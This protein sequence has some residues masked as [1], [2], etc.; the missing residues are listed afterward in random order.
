[1]SVY[2]FIY[3][4]LKCACASPGRLSHAVL[5]QMVS[6][7]MVGAALVALVA[8]SFV[9]SAVAASMD[10]QAERKFAAKPND[11]KKQQNF[12]PN[13]KQVRTASS[14]PRGCA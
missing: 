9:S 5:P 12:L 6:R 3:P 10:A 4:P 7:R 13:N 1:M 14:N 8:S 2:L 11:I